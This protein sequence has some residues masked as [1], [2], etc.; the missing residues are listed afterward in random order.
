MGRLG[1]LAQIAP[2]Y[3]AIAWNGLFLAEI[4]RVTARHQSASATGAALF[5]TFGGMAVG[6][7]AFG[8]VAGA[9]G[10][11]A[12]FAAAAVVTLVPGLW[13]LRAEPSAPVP[14]LLALLGIPCRSL[15]PPAAQLGEQDQSFVGAEDGRRDAGLFLQDHWPDYWVIGDI[16][17]KLYVVVA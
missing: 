12:A 17:A 2:R 14:V 10:Y 4:V 3:A 15:D 16:G 13:L 7:A 6:P 8:L 5:L 11:G 9:F 1:R